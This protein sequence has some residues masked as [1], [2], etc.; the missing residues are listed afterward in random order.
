MK[1]TLRLSILFCSVMFNVHLVHWGEK[2]QETEAI[3]WFKI[4]NN[5]NNNNTHS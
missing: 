3:K 1:V 5:N 2:E 4:T